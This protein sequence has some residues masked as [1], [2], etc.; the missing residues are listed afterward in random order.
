MPEPRRTVLNDF[1]RHLK[2][3]NPKPTT[4]EVLQAIDL[5]VVKEQREA[6]RVELFTRLEGRPIS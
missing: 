3:L 2:I 6:V 1:G 4:D 5:K